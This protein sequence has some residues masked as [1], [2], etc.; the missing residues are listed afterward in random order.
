MKLTVQL[1]LTTVAVVATFNATGQQWERFG[2]TQAG[3]VFFVDTSSVRF[4]SGLV[5]YWVRET[6]PG[7]F[8][9]R[10]RERITSNAGDCQKRVYSITAMTERDSSGSVLSQGSRPQNQ[11]QFAEVTPGSISASA[12][13]RACQLIAAL[14]TRLSRLLPLLPNPPDWQMVAIGTDTSMQMAVSPSTIKD[15]GSG[16][17]LFLAKSEFASAQQTR[18]GVEYRYMLIEGLINC[19]ELTYEVSSQ[20]LVSLDFR[21][22]DA[23]YKT[24]E[25]IRP[26]PLQ[27]GT[28]ADAAKAYVCPRIT[29][30]SEVHASKSAASPK[31]AQSGYGTGWVVD[32]EYVV[33]AYHVIEGAKRITVYASDRLPRNAV[34]AVVDARN[35]LA[36]LR[37]DF[38]GWSP[39]PLAIAKALPILGARVFTIGFPIRDILGVFPKL[40]AGEIASTAGPKDDPRLLQI[41]VPIHSG[42]SGGPLFN[43]SGEVVGIVVSKLDALKMLKE[44]GELPENVGYAMKAR[45]VQ[46]LLD[47]LQRGVKTDIPKLRVA[48]LEQTVAQV[49]DSVVLVVSTPE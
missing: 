46:G 19:S 44:T 38:G 31:D 43:E 37:V 48:K 24:P 49:K 16:V 5:R 40:N 6:I 20:E 1:F 41:S 35:D 23:F 2:H 29:S 26:Q 28:L 7:R 33:T 36:V 14:P 32:A 15:L 25:T 12:L 4:E 9:E 39:K 42:N 22:V 8:L 10:D 45:Y 17:G 27:A 3:S 30:L 47:D 21:V 11:W 13:D 18:A 34:I